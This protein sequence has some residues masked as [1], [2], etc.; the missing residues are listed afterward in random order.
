[1]IL[2][3]LADGFDF[4]TRVIHMHVDDLTHAESLIQP[5][6][7]GNCLNW[8]L[9][10]VISSRHIVLSMVGGQS[11]WSADQL[12][13]YKRESA[14]ITDDGPGVLPLEDLLADLDESGARLVAAIRALPPEAAERSIEGFSEPLGNELLFLYW[15]ESYHIG[16]MDFSRKFAGRTNKLI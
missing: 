4:N 2:T 13:R 16:Q 9:G 14:P 7:N 12:A 8:I 10:H 3:M 5:P 11:L 1:M 6:A 15:H